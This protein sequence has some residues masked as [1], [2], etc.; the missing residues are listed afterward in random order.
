LFVT[1]IE[2]KSR[3]K[4]RARLNTFIAGAAKMRRRYVEDLEGAG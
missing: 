2:K 1:R 3:L 4:G